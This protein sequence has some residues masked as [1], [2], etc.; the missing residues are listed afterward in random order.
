LFALFEPGRIGPIELKNRFVRSATVECLCTDEGRITD[1]YLRA[2]ERLAKGG[3]ALILPGNFYVNPLGRAYP[4]TP[5]V[6]RDEAIDD[7]RKVAAV[8]HEH[9]AKIAA[10][11]NHGGRQ[12]DPKLT[13]ETPVGPSPVRDKLT[14]VKPRQMSEKEIERTIHDF[15]EAARRAREAGFDGVQIHAAHGYLINQFLSGYTNR[16]KDSWGGS[17]ENRMRLLTEVYRTIRSRVGP[18]FPILVKINAVDFA[19]GGV[20]PEECVATCR[21]LEDLGIAAIEVSGGIAEKGLVTIK[22]DIPMD[23]LLKGRSLLERLGVRLL[24][25][26]LRKAA[27]FEEAYFLP[28]AATVK[29]NVSVPVLAVGGMR[30]RRK[31]EAVLESG[32]AD[33]ISM[34]RPFIRQPNLVR[35]LEREEGEPISCTSCNRCSLEILLQHNPMRCYARA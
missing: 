10:Q 26:S 11:L 22:G 18:D 19:K 15:G 8:V 25:R 4:R 17:L 33:Y 3:A 2:Y 7:L 29:K 13:G 31:M 14:F 34:C 35:L 16:R 21:K 6:H 30:T 9:G 12:A 5:T 27:A 1:A 32:Q 24:E 23:L 20:T 28:H